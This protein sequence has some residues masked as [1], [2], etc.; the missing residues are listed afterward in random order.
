VSCKKFFSRALLGLLAFNSLNG[1]STSAMEYAIKHGLINIDDEGNVEKFNEWC[2]KYCFDPAINKDYDEFMSLL[3]EHKQLFDDCGITLKKNIRDFYKE[4]FSFIYLYNRDPHNFCEF[5]NKLIELTDMN[6]ENL[7]N[8][9][10]FS[11]PKGLYACKYG[12]VL[13][14]R[15]RILCFNFRF[16]NEELIDVKLEVSPYQDNGDDEEYE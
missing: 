16:S 15:K 3:N 11:S 6:A 2:G 8:L 10:T 14:D 4:I 12:Y 9:M 7:S 1:V 5:M 13:K